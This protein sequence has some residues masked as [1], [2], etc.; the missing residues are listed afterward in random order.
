M[1]DTVQLHPDSTT[2]DHTVRSEGR[3]F[4]ANSD[5][6]QIMTEARVTNLAQSVRQFTKDHGEPPRNLSDL[7]SC[8]DNTKSKCTSYVDR[9]ASLEPWGNGFFYHVDQAGGVVVMGSFGR[10]GKAG[11]EGVDRD[12]VVLLSTKED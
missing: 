7:W 6:I 12:V 10:D 5:L 8:T 3:L 2:A 1:Y 9:K 11:G 4:E